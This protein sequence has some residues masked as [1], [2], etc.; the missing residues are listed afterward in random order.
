MA[1]RVGRGRRWSRGGQT[2]EAAST[3]GCPVS[4]RSPSWDPTRSP[5]QTDHKPDALLLRAVRAQPEALRRT[6]PSPLVEPRRG[7]TQPD[8]LQ[9]DVL[10]ALPHVAEDGAQSVDLVQA[11]I[12]SPAG[13]SSPPA[14]AGAARPWNRWTRSSRLRRVDLHQTHPT[15]VAQRQRVPV[16]DPSDHPSARRRCRRRSSQHPKRYGHRRSDYREFP[17]QNSPPNYV[18]HMLSIVSPCVKRNICKLTAEIS[19]CH[20]VRN[21]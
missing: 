20:F 13:S 12:S 1:V 7:S 4:W 21:I 8:Q 14:A 2:T 17:S 6:C 3:V 5:A 16:D 9:V 15:P 11:R 18:E 10:G 19:T